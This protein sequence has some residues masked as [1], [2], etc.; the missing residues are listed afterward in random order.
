M[1]AQKLFGHVITAEAGKRHKP[2]NFPLLYY[3]E[4]WLHNICNTCISGLRQK[5]IV[6]EFCL[7]YHE[8]NGLSLPCVLL[9]Q[10]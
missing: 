9:V 6:G 8:K 2:G 5:T 10:K 7:K 1:D 3:S 4:E